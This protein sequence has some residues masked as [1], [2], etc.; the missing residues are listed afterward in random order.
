L[1]EIDRY[2]KDIFGKLDS[3]FP[4][5]SPPTTS[6]PTANNYNDLLKN[7]KDDNYYL[8]RNEEP[9]RFAYYK[10]ARRLMID[11]NKTKKPVPGII[12]TEDLDDYM[13]VYDTT[14]QDAQIAFNGKHSIKLIDKMTLIHRLKYLHYYAK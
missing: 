3:M 4:N 12:K 10:I 6:P 14:T 8:E 1:K 5:L 2:A 9:P 11:G 13:S 7:A